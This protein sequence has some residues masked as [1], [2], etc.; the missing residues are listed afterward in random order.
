M[1]L[2]A[3]RDRLEKIIGKSN[4]LEVMLE[5]CSILTELTERNGAYP[6]I[7]GGLAVEIY[8]RGD[9]T[10]SDIDLVFFERQ[11]VDRCLTGLGFVKWGRHW[12]HEQLGVGVEIP[13]DFLEDADPDRVVKL[14]LEKGHVYV[15]GIED[16]VLDRLRACVHWKSLS[17]CEWGR[18][19][20]LLHRDKVDTAYLLEKAHSEG[21]DEVLSKWLEE[22]GKNR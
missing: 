5:V 16:I 2:E 9:Y 21:I 14:R 4:K 6:I 20:L 15:I 10:T 19:L 11:L 3:A 22:T 1:N 17:D 12:F 13:G 7:V 18:R 8:T